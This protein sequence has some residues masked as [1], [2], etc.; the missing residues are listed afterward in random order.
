MLATGT[1]ES[2]RPL[3][4]AYPDR[5]VPVALAG[6]V[7]TV[8]EWSSLATSDAIGNVGGGAGAVAY[9]VLGALIVRQARNLVGWFMLA[10]GAATAVMTAGSAYAIFGMKAY[11]GTLPAA[12]AAG[13]LA[14]AVF[15]LV[16]A[17]LAALFLVF[18][19]GR[20][21]SPRWRPAAV[22]GLGL[23]GPGSPAG[24]L[25][26]H[27][28]RPG[29]AVPANAGGRAG[30]AGA[31]VPPGRPAAAPADESVSDDGV[32]FPAV[33]GREGSGLQGMSDRLAAHGGTLTVTSQPGQGTA[34]T[35]RLP[36]SELTA[37]GLRPVSL[38]P[39]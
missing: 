35:G 13:A 10:E 8:L 2:W 30:I 28:Q 5:R 31:A 24:H 7:L 26:R 18:P 29:P 1:T 4:P 33:A 19:T 9:A 21:P 12:A 6:L 39:E 22:A 3:C 27:L 32:G 25:A 16:C 38:G 23:T 37:A 34:I 17:A 36:T 11:P 20:L 15:V 14:E